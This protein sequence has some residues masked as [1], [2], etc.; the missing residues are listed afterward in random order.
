MKKYLVIDTESGG[1]SKDFS[2]LSVSCQIFTMNAMHNSLD[3]KVK[4]NDDKYI[5]SAEGISINKIDIVK[6]NKEAIKYKEAKTILYNFLQENCPKNDKLICVGHGIKGDIN[7]LQEYLISIGSW[8]NFVSHHIIDTLVIAKFLQ[9]LDF[10]PE[11]NSLSLESLLKYYKINY[12]PHL[13]HEASYD[14]LKTWDLFTILCN[15]IR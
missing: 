5:L 4:P 13:L 6:H 10:I 1:P 2:L 15:S 14:C 7:I 9:T 12:I 8:N 3:L 11:N